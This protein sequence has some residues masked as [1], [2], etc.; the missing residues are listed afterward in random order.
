[1]FSC[2]GIVSIEQENLNEGEIFHDVSVS[3]RPVYGDDAVED[4]FK[5]YTPLDGNSAILIGGQM[6]HSYG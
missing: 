5:L 4:T 2:T 6:W 1:M 3:S